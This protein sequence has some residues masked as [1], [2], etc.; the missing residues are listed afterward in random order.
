MR[1]AGGALSPE[2]EGG[3]GGSALSQ[4]RIYNLGLSQVPATSKE[5]RS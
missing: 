3:C 4:Q 1:T 2:V 5:K